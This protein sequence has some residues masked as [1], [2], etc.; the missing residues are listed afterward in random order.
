MLNPININIT[1]IGL[2]IFTISGLHLLDNTQAQL[3][4][5][6]NQQDQFENMFGKLVNNITQI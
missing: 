6:K 4:A 5:L 3:D 2:L 1:I